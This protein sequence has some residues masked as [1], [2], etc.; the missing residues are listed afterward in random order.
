MAIQ[1][2]ISSL[3]NLLT[4]FT[5]GG[6]RCSFE[7]DSILL[8]ALTIQISSKQL[9]SSDT[10]ERMSLAEI[11]DSI[12]T[13]KSPEWSQYPRGAHDSPSCSLPFHIESI[14]AELDKASSGLA[15]KGLVRNFREI[16]W[17]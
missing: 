6:N 1:G 5:T 7:C 8:G 13:I 2:T 15:M 3:Q 10:L 17:S 9:L 11:R 4:D 16:K 12:K 14:I